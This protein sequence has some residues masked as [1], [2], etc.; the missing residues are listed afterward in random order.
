VVHTGNTL[1]GEGCH[2]IA[3]VNHGNGWYKYDDNKN[4]DLI[5]HD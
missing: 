3:Y 1:T 5:T 4:P 2:Y